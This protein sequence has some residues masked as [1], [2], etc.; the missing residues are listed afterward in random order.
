M[1]GRKKATEGI[2]A[3]KPSKAGGTKKASSAPKQSA[4]S[5]KN[6]GITKLAQNASRTARAAKGKPAKSFVNTGLKELINE[7]RK[8][9]RKAAAPTVTETPKPPRPRRASDELRNIRRRYERAADR[10]AASAGEARAAGDSR[11]LAEFEAAE[12][13]ARRLSQRLRAENLY[14][15]DATKEQRQEAIARAV[16][17]YKDPSMKQLQRNAGKSE[18]ERRNAMAKAILT[19]R[20]AGSFYAATRDLWIDAPY[21]KRDQ[22]I[23]DAFKDAGYEQINDLIDVMH[24]L[25]QT[26]GIDFLTHATDQDA[27]E[28]YLYE[29]RKGM[30]AIV[31]I[32]NE[33]AR[34]S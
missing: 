21:E 28:R 6:T 34:K 25:Q 33:Q 31:E 10:Y 1:A 23:I 20:G 3:P 8:P 26:T 4:S 14:T 17:T 24:Y 9:P 13:A 11:A 18:T 2:R 27:K 5:I 22:A 30:L 15:R 16:R 32:S 19:N 29:S 12:R 7:S